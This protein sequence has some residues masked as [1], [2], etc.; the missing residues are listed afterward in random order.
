MLEHYQ[1]IICPQKMCKE[2]GGNILG[3]ITNWLSTMGGAGS[4]YPIW[5]VHVIW[6]NFMGNWWYYVL[7]SLQI[8]SFF[9]LFLLFAS[10]VLAWNFSAKYFFSA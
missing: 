8:I 10:L 5:R 7:S 9:S 4:E 2:E 6:N 1:N 3:L